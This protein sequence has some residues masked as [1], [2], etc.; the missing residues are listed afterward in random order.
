MQCDDRKAMPTGVNVQTRIDPAIREEADLVLRSI[1]LSISDVMRVMLRIARE[2]AVPFELVQPDETTID[3]MR[4]ARV[5]RLKRYA[6]V[7]ELTA[8]RDEGD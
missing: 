5:G 1:G 6:S 8:G 2:K 7:A 3:A 4:E